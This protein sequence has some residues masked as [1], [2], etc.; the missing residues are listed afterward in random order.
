VNQ[1]KAYSCKIVDTGNSRSFHADDAFRRLAVDGAADVAIVLGS[2]IA[3]GLADIPQAQFA[4]ILLELQSED[5]GSYIP[6][7]FGREGSNVLG[8]NRFR[9]GEATASDLVEIVAQPATLETAKAAAVAIFQGAGLTTAFCKDMPG[10]IVD[11][12]I[13]P[14]FNQALA[15][16]D[17]ELADADQLDRALM[18]G[19]GY[20]RGPLDLLTE[21]GLENHY[22]VS[23]AIYKATGDAAYLPA[24]RARTALERQ[25][26]SSV[27][28]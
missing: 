9:L 16:L 25:R 11:R 10:R 28:E 26:R 20:R 6:E 7:D 23:D 8:F 13:R 3:R 1:G 14:Y 5:L 22:C 17:D 12:L 18:L 19:L 21:S 24:R 27:H 4:A 2:D 15:A